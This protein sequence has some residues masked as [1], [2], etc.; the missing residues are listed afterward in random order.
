VPAPERNTT[1]VAA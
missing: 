1:A